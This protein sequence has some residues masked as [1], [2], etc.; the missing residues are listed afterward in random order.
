MD[1]TKIRRD[2]EENGT[3][4]KELAAKHGT[5]LSAVKSRKSRERWSR[6][7]G[8]VTKRRTEAEK[9][10]LKKK[11][12]RTT[13][14][15]VHEPIIDAGG[16]GLD[17]QQKLF[18]LHYLKSFNQT[19]AA[20]AA[21]YAANTGN[22][23]MQN[24]KVLQEIQRLKYES[25]K[26]I[27]LEGVDLVEHYARIAFSDITDFIEFG[28]RINERGY[29]EQ[30]AELKSSHEVDGSLIQEIKQ[31]R[32]GFTIKLHDKNKA[33]EFLTKHMDLLGENTK[34]RLENERLRMENELLLTRV[35]TNDNRTQKELAETEIKQIQ[36]EQQRL[37][38]RK[39]ELENSSAI[40]HD[41]F[42]NMTTAELKELIDKGE[43]YE[44]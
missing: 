15:S 29:E 9:L 21:G 24:E 2:W 43:A 39:R 10:Q 11:R 6:D 23:L 8:K 26:L 19:H 41:P 7:P 32:D 37:E 3:L 17:E 13:S 27:F 42:V 31:T 35:T 14:L 34:A 1:W 16:R 38:L 18:C 36:L 4:L 30:Y 33:L 25:R 44:K 12:G 40:E 28:T 20:L 22:K 5:T